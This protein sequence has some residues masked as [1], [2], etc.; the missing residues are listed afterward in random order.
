MTIKNIFAQ[1]VTEEMVSRIEKLTPESQPLWGK[2]NVAEMLAHC[3]VTYEFY[4]E[5]GKHKKPTGLKK[6]LIKLLAKNIVVGPKPYK[7]N[8]PTSPEFKITTKREFE[9]EKSRLIA[10]MRETQKLGGDYFNGKESHAFGTLNT[11]EW[12]NMFYKHLDHHLLQF[13]V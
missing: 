8:S 5:P 11:Q 13:G 10:F 3:C 1:D 6:M 7:R 2:M 9:T 12:N 4:L